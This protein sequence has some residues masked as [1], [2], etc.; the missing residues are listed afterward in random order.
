MSELYVQNINP[1]IGVTTVTVGGDVAANNVNVQSINNLNYPTTGP[2][3]NR[4]LIINGA[5]NVAQR[6]TQVTS[7]TTS[8]YTTCDRFYLSL[9]NL[10]LIHI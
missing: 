7:V 10:S 3:S 2:L 4:N 1:T 5:M 9:I 8:G 6:A